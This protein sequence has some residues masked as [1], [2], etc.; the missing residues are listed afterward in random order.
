MPIIFYAR[1][2]QVIWRFSIPSVWFFSSSV[3]TDFPHVFSSMGYAR[4]SGIGSMVIR[5][6]VTVDE[7]D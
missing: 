2:T 7:L 5:A 6:K 4:L 3:S 1:I